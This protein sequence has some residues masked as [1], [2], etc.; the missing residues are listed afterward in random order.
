[1]TKKKYTFRFHRDAWTDISVEAKSYEE[2]ETLANDKYHNGEYED[3]YEDFE[4]KNVDLISV[5]TV[6]K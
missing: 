4:D 1:M 3:S 6:K 5:E 2:A